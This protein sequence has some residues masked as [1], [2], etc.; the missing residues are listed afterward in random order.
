MAR[1]NG[2]NGRHLDELIEAFYDTAVAVTED[3]AWCG[4]LPKMCHAFDASAVGF[5]DHDFALR[6]GFLRHEFNSYAGTREAHGGKGAGPA[7]WI[8][9]LAR[10]EEGVAVCGDDF[11]VHGDDR[12]NGF[13]GRNGRPQNLSHRLCGVITRDG[14]QAYLVSFMRRPEAAAFD[15]DDKV[16]L[17][18][19]LPH[20][21]RSI[22]VREQ[23]VRDR[24]AQESLAEFIDFLPI[25]FLLVGHSG[26]V[27]LLN[28]VARQM[29][30]RK[31]GL[32]VGAG[33]YLA[34]ASAKNTA[35]L[36]K[37]IAETA[38]AAS[39]G[40]SLLQ[41]EHFII[42]RGVDRLPLICVAYPVVGSRLNHEQGAKPA[43]A[44]L[45]KDPQIERID[46]LP[47][48]ANAYGLTNAETKLIGSLTAGH[49]LFETAA[50]LGISKNT[51]R[52]H[53]R[54]IYA[55]VGTNRQADLI[56]LFAQFSLF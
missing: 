41:E 35:D 7:P 42:S 12:S 6:E 49:G 47:D 52:T 38:A 39:R 29:I 44:V 40:Q 2:Q 15:Q 31:D 28:S 46:S 37:F 8:D 30:A 5:L 34:T 18:A 56:R 27:E 4:V 45:I 3:C 26:Q 9:A 55:K 53:M 21:K 50:D 51:A 36:R 43:V 48:F 10:F 1:R 14:Q 19:L 11:L 17:S 32:F 20:L 54:N 33:G 13:H 24:L 22:K 23:I 16:A 25:A